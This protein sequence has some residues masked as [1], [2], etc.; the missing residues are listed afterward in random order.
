M[1]QEDVCVQKWIGGL[2]DRTAT[3]RL[4]I[5]KRFFE[6]VDVGP[7]EAVGFQRGHPNDY[8]FVDGAYKWVESLSLAASSM[9]VFVGTVRGFFLAN[10]A[11]LPSDKHRFHSDKER[12]IGELTVEEFRR[13][14]LGCNRTYQPAFLVMFQSGSGVGEL[15]YINE[16][17]AGYVWDEVRKGSRLIKLRMPGRKQNRNVRPYYTFI[18]SDAIDALK[19]LFHSRGWKREKYLFVTEYGEPVTE[20]SLGNYF[21]RH[22]FRAGIVKRFAPSCL[23]CGGETVKRVRQAKGVRSEHYVCLQCP[24]NRAISEYGL[25]HADCGG[26]RYRVRTHEL[27]DLF[28]T[29]CHYA[30]TYAG[31]DG[32]ACQFF[33]GHSIDPLEY[34]KIM[35]DHA[36]ATSEYR[37]A[38][39]FLN[40]LSQEP[41]KVERSTV[42]LRFEGQ[43]V[44]M[45]K[46]MDEVALL[47][48][49]QRVL[50]DPDVLSALKELAKKVK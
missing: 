49:R 25:S 17:H 31:F 13:I 22:A 2:A 48:S 27:R 7:S 16:H 34:D 30:Q 14:L 24:S 44:A 41:L 29:Q 38:M 23:D 11:P 37:K 20:H 50:D 47:R 43:K 9:K 5:L 45:E 32:S 33:M 6:F 28:R 3:N 26:I 19:N 15:C 4:P 36:Y 1:F 35:R 12:V 39:P 42:D 46:L 8:R 21:R 18:G 40:I 10:R